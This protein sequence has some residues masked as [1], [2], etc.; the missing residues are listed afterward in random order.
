MLI[1]T[2]ADKKHYSVHYIT[3]K[4]Y[5]SLCMVVTKGHRA[6]KFRQSYWLRPYMHLN[7]EKRKESRNKFEESFFKVMNNL[8]YGKILESKRNCLTVQLVT[9]R[10]HLP[11]S[12]DNTFFC[13]FK[14]F[15]EILAAILSRRRSILW[16]DTTKV[17]AVVVDLTKYHMFDFHYNV[18]KKH[19]NCAVLYSDTD[20]LLYDIKHTDFY[21]KLAPNNALRQHFDLSNYPT[22][23]FLYNV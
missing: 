21:E 12:T 10:E 7:T 13:N 16:N 3:L 14:T 4:L 15:N 9:S 2:L 1:Q 11:G 17:G 8:C 18:M 5:V 20:S 19:L 23:H 6:L 22:D